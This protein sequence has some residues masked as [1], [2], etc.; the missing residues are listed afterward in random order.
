MAQCPATIRC[1]YVFVSVFVFPQIIY[2]FISY[3]LLFPFLDSKELTQIMDEGEETT[4][5]THS[6]EEN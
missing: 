5:D 1:L 4:R 2:I 6:F 3:L